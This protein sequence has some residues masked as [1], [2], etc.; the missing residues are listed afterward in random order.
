MFPVKDK[1]L[2]FLCPYFVHELQIL[3]STSELKGAVLQVS[4]PE[5]QKEDSNLETILLTL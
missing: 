1:R 2:R 5:V 3:H 4:A